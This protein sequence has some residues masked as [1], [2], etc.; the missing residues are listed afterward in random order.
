MAE[1]SR[2]EGSQEVVVL[3]RSNYARWRIEVE[4]AL[5]GR[6]LYWHASGA[7]VQVADPG[8]EGTAA[9]IKKYREWDEKDSKARSLILR[10]LDDESFSHVADCLTSKAVLDRIAELRD[11]KTTDALM[12]G[13]NAFFVEQWHDWDDVSS[14]LA[15]ITVHAARVNGCE[16]PQTKITDQ[17]VMG[18]VLAVLPARFET[19]AQSWKLIAKSDTSLAEF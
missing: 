1:S 6:G 2:K 5:R 11:P 9:A 13:V 4:A 3:S 19:F 17:L 14:F 18:K 15:R 7:E 12:T 8:P 16:H 10:S